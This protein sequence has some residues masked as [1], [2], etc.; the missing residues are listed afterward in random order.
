MRRIC[1]IFFAVLL[2]MTGAHAQWP[3]TIIRED[4]GGNM[5]EYADKY[6]NMR[7]WR[8][9]VVID[10]PCASA[11]TLV[12]GN[13]GAQPVCVTNHAKLGFHAAWDYGPGGTH[14]TNPAATKVLLD[15]YSVGVRQWIARHGGLTKKMI[16]LEGRQLQALVPPCP[17]QS[18]PTGDQSS[19]A[20]L[21]PNRLQR[22]H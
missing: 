20:S 19:F 4:P 11:C 17:S 2:T 6:K 1:I 12:L 21:P 15:S 9:S 14:V 22:S 18:T 10:G 8:D 7:F 3:G 5:G 13:I 16:W